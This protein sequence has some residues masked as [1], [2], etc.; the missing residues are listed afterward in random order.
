MD[1]LLKVRLRLSEVILLRE[2]GTSVRCCGMSKK[3]YESNCDSRVTKAKRET[4]MK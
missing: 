2:R 4:G 1:S 3:A